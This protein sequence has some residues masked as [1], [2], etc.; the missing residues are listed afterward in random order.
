MTNF[1]QFRFAYIIF[2]EVL[3]IAF[4]CGFENERCDTQKILIISYTIYIRFD[5]VDI[6]DIETPFAGTDE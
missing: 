1:S 2:F 5:D 4:C 3:I 6:A